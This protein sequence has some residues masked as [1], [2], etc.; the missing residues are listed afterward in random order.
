MSKSQ[1]LFFKYDI[2]CE[3]KQKKGFKTMQFYERI[4]ALREDNELKQED[5]AQKLNTNQKRISR[6][7]LNLSQ[8]TVN[9]I[10]EYCKIFNVSADYILGISDSK[11]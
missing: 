7:E 10:I 3:N 6:L 9:D 4:R 11:K 1:Y 8:P 5:I 2:I